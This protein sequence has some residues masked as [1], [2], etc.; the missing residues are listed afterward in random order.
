MSNYF[1]QTISRKE[2]RKLAYAIRKEFGYLHEWWIPVETLLDQMCKV[3]PE[4]SYEIID[5]E[6]WHDPT[7]YADTDI[8]EKTIRIRE[9]VYEKACKGYGC[10]RMII[11]HEIAHYF[12]ICV[13]RLN[14]YFSNGEKIKPCNDPEW[15]AK[16]LAGELLIPYYI[17]KHQN[18]PIPPNLLASYCGVSYEAAIYQLKFVSGGDVS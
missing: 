7:A 3:F 16:C 17:L 4:F 2:M 6:E 14:L 18:K 8:L 15:Q 12:L 9:S 5:D 10:D 13:I 1:S 11:A